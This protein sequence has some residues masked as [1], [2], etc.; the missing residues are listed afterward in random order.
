M[1][2]LFRDNPL[3][4]L[5]V[6]AAIGYLIGNFKIRG[7]ALGVSAVLFVG[8][9]FGALDN[10]FK[11]PDVVLQLGLAIF[12][13]SVGLSSGPAFFEMYRK[14][15]LKDFI[16]IISML[17]FTGIITAGLWYLFDFSAANATGIYTGSTTNTAALAGVLDYMA[18]N[19]DMG[20]ASRLADEAVI[21]YSF[22]YPMGVLGGMIAIVWAKKWLKIDFKEEAKKWRKDYPLDERLTSCAVE[23]TNEGVCGIDLRDLMLNYDWN[24]NF[25]R[26]IKDGQLG[27][28]N[29]ST[30]F[31][32]GDKIIVV[33]NIED[34]DSVIQE[35]GVRVKMPHTKDSRA[36]DTRSI[37]VSNPDVAGNTIA[38]LNLDEKYNAVITRIRRGDVEM[39]A[40]GDTVLELGD[41]IRFMARRKDLKVLSELFGD[42]YHQSSKINLFSFGI[43]MGLGLILGNITFDLGP[44]FSFKLGYAGGPL[45]VGLILGGIRRTGKVLWTLPYG[46][47][48][49][50]QQIGLILLLAALGVRSGSALVQSL[51]FD[52]LWIVLASGIISLA[53]ALTIL[54][55]G[56]KILKRPFG[57]LMG[58]VAN[59]PAIL[60][61]GIEQANNRLPMYGFTLMFPIALILKILIAQILFIVLS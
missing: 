6:V 36:Y 17:C 5:F 14:H 53:T 59:Q 2:E 35:F 28:I 41:R 58:M 19:Y 48:V 55:L 40:K 54:F 57:L 46:A 9:F 12:V 34:I 18:G 8:L 52:A 42:S 22:S 25:G 32:V 11:I 7:S 39:L 21:G 10:Q 30:Q 3:V 29:W 13:Y 4:L 45:I 61:F 1:I 49:T 44:S 60:D 20:T 43:G 27:L 31:Q 16:F 38:S 23:I 15:G 50:L 26:I 33:G 47:N 24:V 51:S 56:Y 37:F